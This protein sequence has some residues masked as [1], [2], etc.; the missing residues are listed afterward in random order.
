MGINRD[1]Y[2][3]TDYCLNIAELDADLLV[4]KLVELRTNGDE[5]RDQLRQMHTSQVQL[6]HQAGED[7]LSLV[8]RQD[9]R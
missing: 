6:V 3:H 8:M 7:V 9:E 5:I 2:G 4:A 1:L